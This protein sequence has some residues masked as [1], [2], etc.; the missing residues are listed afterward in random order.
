MI[1]NIYIW[2]III[3]GLI[4][5]AVGLKTIYLFTNNLFEEEMENDYYKGD[6]KKFK[7]K[8]YTIS[9]GYN[10]MYIII[11]YT[12]IISAIL[13]AWIVGVLMTVFIM[14]LTSIGFVYF[15]CIQCIKHSANPIADSVAEPVADSVAEPYTLI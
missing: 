7:L 9:N 13:I 10:A 8:I 4:C 5:E 11:L 14:I 12:Y 6:F 15:I 1:S 3:I 2:M